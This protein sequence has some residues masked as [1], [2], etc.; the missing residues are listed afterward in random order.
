MYL[1]HFGLTQKPFSLIPDPAFIHFSK[2]HQIAY[3]MLEYGLFEQTGITL[4]TGEVGSGKTT[5]LQHLLNQVDQQALS[6]GLIN[7]THKNLGSLIDWI[8]LAFNIP[9]E[10]QDKVSLYNAIQGFIIEQYAQQKRSVIII[11][12]AQN[13]DAESLEELRLLTNINAN[14]DHLLQIVL[15]GQPELIQTLEQPAL[16]QIAQRIAIE[17]HLKALSLKESCDYIEH[18]LKVAGAQEAIIPKEVMA[19]IC[20]HT[21][22][23]PRLINTLCDSALVYAYAKDETC[24]ST[25]TIL[26]VVKDRKISGINRFAQHG[27]AAE[28]IRQWVFDKVGVEL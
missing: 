9:H 4:I 25:D 3:H 12:E 28:E 26:E 18:R 5:L 8:A 24:V 21:G 20:Y 17:Y 19:I 13:M 11:D 23:I 10:N 6:I 7:N 16:A 2:K 1:K 22:G 14:K 27:Q 15:I